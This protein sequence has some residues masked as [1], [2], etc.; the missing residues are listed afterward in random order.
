M[1]I[2]CMIGGGALGTANDAVLKGLT[3]GYPVGEIMFVRGFFMMIPVAFFVWRAGGITTLITQNYKD[4]AIRAGL[5]ICGTYL[6]VSG[7]RYL[8][9]AN[10]ISIAF[11]GPLFITALAG[12]MLGE[13]VGWRRWMAVLAGFIGIL[14]IFQPGGSVFQWAALFPLGASCTGALR[15]I[16]TRKMSARESS[17]S[18]LTYSTIG[19][20]LGGLFSLPFGWQPVA[21]ADWMYFVFNGV[22]ISGAHFLMIE[23]FRHAEAALVAPFKYTTVIWATLFGYMFFAEVPGYN[24]IIGGAVVI[25]SGIYIL[26]REHLRRGVRSSQN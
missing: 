10:A 21:S 25:A 3:A 17:V 1:G 13:R 23:T 22:L 19:V 5:M 26:H 11:A 2:A 24:L 7:L 6:F 15:D 4:H 12:P 16:L 14:I 20:T 8:P 18:M 9:L